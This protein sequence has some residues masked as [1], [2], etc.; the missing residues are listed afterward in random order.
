VL[1][2][3]KCQARGQITGGEKG[4]DE[5]YKI[6]LRCGALARPANKARHYKGLGILCNKKGE[7]IMAVIPPFQTLILCNKKA[8]RIMVA[9][10]PFQTLILCN[11]EKLKKNEKKN[12]KR[13]VHFAANNCCK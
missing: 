11:K 9:I 10:P 6:S 3:V 8:H 4:G 7:K 1:E 12:Q 13:K 2:H 5:I